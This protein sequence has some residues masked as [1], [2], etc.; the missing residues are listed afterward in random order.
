MTG[1]GNAT[2]SSLSSISPLMLTSRQALLTISSK[3]TPLLTSIAIFDLHHSKQIFERIAALKLLGNLLMIK[4]QKS[5]NIYKIVPVIVDAMVKVLDVNHPS[6][7]ESLQDIVAVNI[8]EIVVK[9]PC[10][11][12]HAK[13]QLLAS[14]TREGMIIIY[15]LRTGIRMSSFQVSL[16]YNSSVLVQFIVARS[17]QVVNL[18]EHCNWRITSYPSIKYLLGL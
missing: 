8:A 9:Y 4:D 18:L 7:R 11:A 12:F 10:I 14:G 17:H 5:L 3:N 13:L 2:S 1:L 15:D 16:F 6:I